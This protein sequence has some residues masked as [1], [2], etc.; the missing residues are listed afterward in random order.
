MKCTR[1]CGH[2]RTVYV[3]D[4]NESVRKA[5]RRLIQS[6]GL[7]ARAFAS[8]EEFLEA[9]PPPPDCL[10]LDVRMPGGLSGLDL[11]QRLAGLEP[12]VPIVFVTAHEDEPT[13]ER[14]LAA[15]AVAFLVK[16]FDDQD[17]LDA[18]RAATLT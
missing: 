8:A 17:L 5:V 11:Q 14:A 1:V 15:G 2:S 3:I 10:I 9:A 16:P 4:D 6:A 18:V 13:R 12:S 7:V